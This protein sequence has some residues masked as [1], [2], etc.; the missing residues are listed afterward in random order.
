MVGRAEHMGELLLTWHGPPVL[1]RLVQQA[2]LSQTTEKIY[3][4]VE[5]VL[6]GISLST[7]VNC[8]LYLKNFYFQSFLFLRLTE[9][10]SPFKNSR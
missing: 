2:H 4:H 6:P 3:S 7:S 8:S 9:S 10:A 1:S 5:G